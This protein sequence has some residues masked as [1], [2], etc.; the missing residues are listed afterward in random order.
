[1]NA[2]QDRFVFLEVLRGLLAGFRACVRFIATSTSMYRLLSVYRGEEFSTR[3]MASRGRI[4]LYL[5]GFSWMDMF[6]VERDRT[7]FV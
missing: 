3:P 1:M 5:N 2:G 6:D 4:R 7:V